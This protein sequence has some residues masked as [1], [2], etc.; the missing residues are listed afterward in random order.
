MNRLSRLL[1]LLAATAALAV[2]GVGR[3]S[4]NVELLDV[5][6]A[7]LPN[8][9]ALKTFREHFDQSDNLMLVL[10]HPDGSR[11]G[12]LAREAG[13]HLVDQ[14]FA[15]AFDA[16]SSP[17]D[18]PAALADTLAYL[19]FNSQAATTAAWTSTLHPEAIP[20]LLD[21]ALERLAT[22]DL[23]GAGALQGQY[24]PYGLLGHP[25]LAN[26]LASAPQGDRFASPDG[27][28]RLIFITPRA[29][30]KSYRQDAEWLTAVRTTLE[31]WRDRDPQRAGL[32]FSFTGEAPYKVAVSQM[33]E[34]DLGQSVAWTG[35]AVALLFW[36]TQ[37]RFA[38][39]G[40]LLLCLALSFSATLAL[41][42][43]FFD[44]LSIMSIGFA[45]ILMGLA[46]DYGVLSSQY[47]GAFGGSASE[48]RRRIGRSIIWAAA[49]TAL[50]FLMLR[51]SAFPGI[52]QLGTIVA[53]GIC[54]AALVTLFIYIPLLAG[55]PPRPPAPAIAADAP[56]PLLLRER[57]TA[58]L[59]LAAGAILV[60]AFQGPPAIDYRLGTPPEDKLPP[61][62]AFRTIQKEI[63]AWAESNLALLVI[64][65]S[66]D[67]LR[68]RA[69]I[70]KQRLDNMR[71]A[72]LLKRALLPVELWP[73][74]AAQAANRAPLL[75]L[76]SRRD[77][78]LAAAA[79]AG[80][81]EEGTALTARVFDGFRDLAAQAAPAFPANPAA[82]ALL[83]GFLAR[84]A[85]TRVL[86][87]SL[88]PADYEAMRRADFEALAPLNDEGILL[89]SWQT[90][91]SGIRPLMLHDAKVVVLPTAAVLLLMLALLF[92]RSTEVLLAIAFLAFCGLLLNAWMAV[93][94]EP[95]TFQN[96]A[97]VPVLLGTGIDYVIHVLLALRRYA[98]DR[99][100]LWLGTGKALV[101]CGGTTAAG[102][103]SL[104]LATDPGLA[105]FARIACAGILIAMATA[106]LLLPAWWRPARPQPASA[107]PSA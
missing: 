58:T 95:W 43:L 61:M 71:A 88:A 101:F 8:V 41:G 102:F 6:P 76:A 97:A 30:S 65:R 12:E 25:F 96:F 63:P 59:L 44:Q 99:R 105:S 19:W 50:V 70:A 47:H 92:R 27:R 14:N 104:T 103:G 40:W 62:Q 24:D 74:A 39:L 34:R 77:E 80:F 54:A 66:D 9:K 15:S 52:A 87:G 35:L 67:E 10:R 31:A 20:E 106:I 21:E 49:T 13:Q 28:L 1:L 11:L 73:D 79:A 81:S 89:A 51:L 85:D 4:L 46:A 22:G 3:I 16:G 33:M 64:G 18:D 32:E 23:A 42:A 2:F 60:L 90:L 69:A 17:L 72:G 55:G 83:G 94:G 84:D 82:R 91:P 68:Q 75:Q 56:V 7:D 53:I 37:R 100:K 78:L 107:P 48:L 5:L 26:L 86:V 93:V 98:G 57:G 36:L 29:P 38:A 45:S